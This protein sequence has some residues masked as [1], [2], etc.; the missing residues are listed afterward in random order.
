MTIVDT[1]YKRHLSWEKSSIIVTPRGAVGAFSGPRKHDSFST[2]TNNI[3]VVTLI[4]HDN[5]PAGTASWN[6]GSAVLNTV[7]SLGTV[8]VA[9]TR[10]KDIKNVCCTEALEFPC[11]FHLNRIC[12]VPLLKLQL[13]ATCFV[14]LPFSGIDAFSV[15]F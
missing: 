14:W 10:W 4:L 12:A 7:A 11:S 5:L 2:I 13:P 6:T 8:H 9:L 15:T 1:T 3:M